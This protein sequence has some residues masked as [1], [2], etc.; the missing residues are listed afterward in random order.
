MIDQTLAGGVDVVDLVSEVTEGTADAVGFRIP[1]PG[2]LDLGLLVARRS[3][4]YQ[5]ETPLL[6]LHP[7]HFTQAQSVAVKTQ[8]RRQ[9]RD[10]HHSVQVPHQRYPQ[11]QSQPND[12]RTVRPARNSGSVLAFIS[13]DE[14]GLTAKTG[15][16][17][18]DA[19]VIRAMP[20]RWAD[21]T[22]RVTSLL[23]AGTIAL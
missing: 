23:L 8:R 20:H 18:A 17:R 14:R 15:H 11:Q 2:E 5:R 4:E 22:R 6:V 7:A 3:Q 13:H 1:V 9:I 19:R 21:R 10:A 12:M 16:M